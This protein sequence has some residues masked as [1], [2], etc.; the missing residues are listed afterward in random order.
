MPS[1][2]REIADGQ[3]PLLTRE[4]LLGL[5]DRFAQEFHSV[6]RQKD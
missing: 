6:F 4:Q 3:E 1:Y 5:F 2:V